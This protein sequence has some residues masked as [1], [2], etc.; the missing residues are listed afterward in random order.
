ML[1][2]F[3]FFSSYVQIRDDHN[4]LKTDISG[5][6]FFQQLLGLR[7]DVLA[8]DH[9]FKLCNC[10]II[11]IPVDLRIIDAGYCFLIVQIELQDFFNIG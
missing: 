9:I 2:V 6:Y 1:V 8:F 4:G 10:F 3:T 7:R 5:L 11:I